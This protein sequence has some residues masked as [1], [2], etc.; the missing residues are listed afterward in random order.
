MIP[1][2]VIPPIREYKWSRTFQFFL[3]MICKFLGTYGERWIVE[4]GGLWGKVVAEAMI[5]KKEE[6]SVRVRK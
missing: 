6:N 3:Y 1:L 5:Y 4:K 2:R